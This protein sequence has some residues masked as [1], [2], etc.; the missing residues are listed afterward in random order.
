MNILW[1]AREYDVW[2]VAS[3]FLNTKANLFDFHLNCGDIS[4]NASR[5]FEWR[6]YYNYSADITRNRC[7]R[8]ACGNNDLIDKKY[9]DAFNYYITNEDKFANSCYYFD[10]GYVHWV[11]LNSNT[12]STYVDGVGNVGGYVDTNAF[13]EAQAQWLDQHLTQVNQRAVKP[14]WIIV[15][16]HLSPFTVTRAAR[17]QRWIAPIEK[18]K[19]DL[20]LCGK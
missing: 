9:S 20:F 17:L 18:H 3:R 15:Y 8:I 14:R 13:L 16:A 6:Y 19:V 7:H 2:S 12:D 10:L 11:C 5:A 4:Q 1:S